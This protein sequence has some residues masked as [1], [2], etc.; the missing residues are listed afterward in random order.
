MRRYQVVVIL[1]ML[2]LLTTMSNAS[3][4]YLWHGIGEGGPLGAE[5]HGLMGPIG[6]GFA[7]GGQEKKDFD[8]S[9]SDAPLKERQTIM[10]AFYEWP[11]GN[12][13][14]GVGVTNSRRIETAAKKTIVNGEQVLV[15]VTITNETK[16]SPL[17]TLRITL[18]ESPIFAD[19]YIAASSL[20][21]SSTVRAGWSHGTFRAGIGYHAGPNADWWSGLI[22]F[23]GST[24]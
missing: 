1:T 9:V 24:F 19:G 23:V 18:S 21:V 3:D 15:P 16:A 5:F 20:G 14:I 10:R 8:P 6:I 13:R 12:V 2:F 4:G 11:L 22:V 7:S 17:A